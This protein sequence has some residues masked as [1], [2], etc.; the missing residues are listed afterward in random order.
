MRE[1]YTYS[2]LVLRY[3][4]TLLQYRYCTTHT[5]CE[6]QKES[7]FSPTQFLSGILCTPELLFYLAYKYCDYTEY[8]WMHNVMMTQ[9]VFPSTSCK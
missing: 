4:Y 9:M 8:T 6:T 5:C 1:F 7:R 2:S 3:F